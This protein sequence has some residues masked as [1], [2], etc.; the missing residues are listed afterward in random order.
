MRR[1]LLILLLG[2]LL[3]GC[4]TDTQRSKSQNPGE[5]FAESQKLH[6]I[7]DAYFEEYLKLAPLFA[8]SIGDHR[9]N[10]RLAIFI[11]E[12]SRGRRRA[13]YQ[14][15]QTETTKLQKDRLKTDDRLILAVFERTLT[16]NLE[17]LQFDQ[18]LQP[19][20]QLNSLA[21]DF[22]VIGSGNELQPFNTVADYNNFLKRIDQFQIWADT[23]IGNMQKGI[24]LGVVQPTVVMQR[25]LP[26]LKA[27]I[28]GAPEESLFFRPILQMPPDF[29]ES[30]KARLTKAYS[31]AIDQKIIPTY[32]KLH[33]FIQQE[34]LPHTRTTYGISSL[35]NG[36]AWYEYLVRT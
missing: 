30:E 31:Q 20:R 19:V 9:Y 28:V 26:Q 23:A 12:E 6:R 32:R 33:N 5:P 36:A 18:H 21:V 7:L 17:A 8:T 1:H 13:L 24:A 34:Y 27:M 25:T 4:A 10:D 3:F 35:P 11:G 14:R 15:Y 2:A 16:R 29:S 22:P